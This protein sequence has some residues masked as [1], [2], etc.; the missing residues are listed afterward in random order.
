MR[1]MHVVPVDELR[2]LA[3]GVALD[4]DL[5]VSIGD[6]GS[7][8]FI[9]PKTGMINVD[10]GDLERGP[11][12]DVRGLICH[13]AAHAAVTRYLHLVP[14]DIIK[15]TG[16]ASLLN[17]LEDCRIED[18]LARRY[19]GTE[20][21]IEMYNDRLFPEDAKGLSEQPW[22]SQFCLGAIHEWWHGQ[23]PGNL[24]D[25][26][27]AALEATREARQRYIDLQPPVEGD[28]GLDAVAAYPRSRVSALYARDDLFGPPDAFERAVRL[29]AYD[30]WRILWQEVKPTYLDLVARDK[31]HADKMKAHE[32][33]FLTRLGELR[34]APPMRGARRRS[35]LPVWAGLPA[36]PPT[37][38]APDRP[39][40]TGGVGE[41]P[42]E[43]RD[44]MRAVVE[45][46]PSGVYEEARRD[47][48]PLAD[49]LFDELERILRPESYPRWVSHFPYGS[50]L[51]VRVAMTVDVEP[52]SYLRMWQRKTIP[53][54][55]EPSFLLLLDLS[56]SMSGER[57]HHGFRGAV[58]V[59]E[60][61][62]RLNVPFA[63][64]GFQDTLVPFKGFGDPLD[65]AMREKIGGM[66]AEVQGGRPGGHNRPEHNWDGPVLERASEI[67]LDRPPGTRVLLVVSDGEPSGPSDGEQAL[68]RAVQRIT[69]QTDLMLLGVG[70]GPG[71]EHVARY[72]PDH[73]AS[74]PLQHFPAALGGLIERVLKR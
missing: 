57:I 74:V 62:A 55:R 56:G 54:K 4:A 69:R 37:G 11:P 59:A 18:W 53:K 2:A 21:W 13:E 27:R 66:P 12:D 58:L 17:S 6:P 10:G 23:M 3:R 51:D 71:T 64:Y 26:P 45:A 73:L 33:Q 50:R 24:H 35:G 68:T 5:E 39:P 19:P 43:L 28:V 47:V 9:D 29:T 30:A 67:L 16:M 60:V 42:P 1:P 22:F 63:V 20:P 41:L 44:A 25:E 31:A 72:Y 48:A 32:Q 46:P 61:L 70:L 40:G 52:G 7:G 36:G 49:R 65:V 15:T 38:P 14:R 8:W 34:Y